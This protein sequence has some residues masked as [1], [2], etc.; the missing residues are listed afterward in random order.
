MLFCHLFYFF[1]EKLFHHHDEN[2]Q[3]HTSVTGN[4]PSES[5]EKIH[6]IPKTRKHLMTPEEPKIS[7]FDEKNSKTS[8][9]VVSNFFGNNVTREK[10]IKSESINNNVVYLTQQQQHERPSEPP[11][12]LDEK[13]K[14]WKESGYK[15]VTEVQYT[16]KGKT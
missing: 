5:I 3:P 8:G 9:H 7:L 2:L 4:Y 1:I 10:I 13:L 6:V 12:N 15:I 14:G 16:D 11:S